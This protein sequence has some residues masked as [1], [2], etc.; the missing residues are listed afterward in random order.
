MK[1]KKPKSL[2]SGRLDIKSTL[3]KEETLLPFWAMI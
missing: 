1:K 2:I 3:I